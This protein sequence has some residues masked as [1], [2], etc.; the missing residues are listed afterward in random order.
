MKGLSSNPSLAA[1][2]L[3]LVPMVPWFLSLSFVTFRMGGQKGVL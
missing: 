3:A 2:I 1:Q